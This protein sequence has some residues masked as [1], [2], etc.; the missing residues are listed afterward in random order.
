LYTIGISNIRK[1]ESASMSNVLTEEEMVLLADYGATIRGSLEC[2]ANGTGVPCRTD[3]LYAVE[4][5]KRY[6]A[7]HDYTV[8]ENEESNE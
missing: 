3:R 2:D 8:T 6:L 1:K 5:M 7:I 4:F